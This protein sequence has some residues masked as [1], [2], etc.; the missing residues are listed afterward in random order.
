[1]GKYIA[2]RILLSIPVLLGVILIIFIMLNVIPGDPVTI[3]MNEHIKPDIIANMRKSMHLDDPIYVRFFRYIGDALHGDLGTSY[4]MNRPVNSLIFEAFP[5][6][7]LLAVCASLVSWVIGIP[8]GVFSAV[9]KNSLADRFS[10]G[11][12]LFGVSMPVFFIGLIL[13]Y[14]FQGMLPVS[15]FSSW[16]HLILP[17]IVL[18][19]NAA[20]RIA[21][22]TRSSL[23][24]VMKSD[25]I[26]TARAKGLIERLVVSRHALKNSLLP[27]ITVMAI[28]VADMLSGAVI[29]E[30]IFGI[31]GIGRLSVT[32][33]QYR[34]MPLLQGTVIFTTIIIIL[35]N[36]IADILYSVID[37][38]I[39]VQ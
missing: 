39:R 15:G 37:P 1:M 35:G 4:K 18:G 13:Q 21:R 16:R 27:V 9:K 10:M 28:Q 7:L 31:P 34:D 14:L 5:N 32:A 26:R 17:S 2:K 12:A 8:V 38:R 3:M 6:T 25:Y 11:F 20:G 36:L 29:T 24:G 30:T 23:L 19:W 33:I 22:L